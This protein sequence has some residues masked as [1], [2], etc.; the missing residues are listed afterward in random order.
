MDNITITN[1]LQTFYTNEMVYSQSGVKFP[2]ALTVRQ[3][4]ALMLVNGE[5][6]F[7]YR[8][9]MIPMELIGEIVYI[10]A[11]MQVL[12]Q[13]IDVKEDD[14]KRNLIAAR[15]NNMFGCL[16]GTVVFGTPVESAH[17]YKWP[18]L[19][20]TQFKEPVRNVRGSLKFWQFELRS[21]RINKQ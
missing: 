18:V 12:R 14:Y 19:A 13:I 8:N 1:R 16:I 9:W 20:Q 21:T 17:G 15:E 10:H 4:Y 5:K 11:G 3:P 6:H 2:F 7:E